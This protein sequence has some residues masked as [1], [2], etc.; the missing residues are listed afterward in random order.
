MECSHLWKI[1]VGFSPG[2]KKTEMSNLAL[3][4]KFEGL[5]I[6]SLLL[7]TKRTTIDIRGIQSIATDIQ[8]TPV[9]CTDHQGV[10]SDIRGGIQS[11][12]HDDA[13]NLLQEF[14]G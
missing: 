2:G 11:S 4:D 7:S 12:R 5:K 10:S 8:P 1:V 9:R 14:P 13:R 3:I 6:L